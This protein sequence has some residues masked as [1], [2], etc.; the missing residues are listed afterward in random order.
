MGPG[1]G[2]ICASRE[3]E[4]CWDGRMIKPNRRREIRSARSSYFHFSCDRKKVTVE[5][6]G[7][8]PGSL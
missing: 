7:G 6:N 3:I 5:P 4:R 1:S 8:Q 2:M